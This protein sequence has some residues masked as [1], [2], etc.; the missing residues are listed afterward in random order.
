MNAGVETVQEY[1]AGLLFEVI[2]AKRIRE[3][4]SE[5]EAR[6]GLLEGLQAIAEDPE[7]LAEWSALAE[8]RG[9]SSTAL[10]A[11]VQEPVASGGETPG[12]SLEAPKPKVQEYQRK[13]P[14]VLVPATLPVDSLSVASR[15]VL[16]H[17]GQEADDPQAFL[18]CLRRGESI[19]VTEV[20]ELAQA[21][22]DL[23]V[24][25]RDSRTLDRRIVFALHRLAYEGQILHTDA[26][27]GAFDPWT[28]EAL[29]AVQEAVE[30]I[31]S[32][33]DIRYF[34]NDHSTENPR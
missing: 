33:Q 19:S 17:A 4:A 28:V 26:W 15:A 31:L 12:P 14:V 8:L 5:M 30:R 27:P 34:P 21:L 11:S 7:Y 18:P 10:P 25:V 1:C 13:A 24:E 16:R 3:Q 29:R 20:A 23:E 32:G 2:E 6:Q 9:Q 22:Q